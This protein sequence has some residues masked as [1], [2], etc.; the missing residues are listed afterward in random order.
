[1]APATDSAESARPN[2]E[3]QIPEK[4]YSGSLEEQADAAL[5][6]FLDWHLEGGLEPYAHQEE[7]LLEISEIDGAWKLT[8]LEILDEQR[9]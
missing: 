1:M 8:G 4:G 3:S 7:A 2:L 5:S 6:D 9:L